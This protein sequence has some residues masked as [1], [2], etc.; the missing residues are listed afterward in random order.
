MNLISYIEK[1]GNKTFL[2]KPLNGVDKLILSNLSYV[3]FTGIISK[4]SLR[5][6]RL[7]TAG[8][9]FFNNKYDKGKKMLAVKGGIKLLKAM[10]KTDRY[11]NL[12]LFNYE[13]IGNYITEHT[14]KN[15]LYV[16]SEEFRDEFTRKK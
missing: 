12:L 5:K 16:T 3:E 8:E 13:S 2:D 14:N 1:Y 4:G 15:V 9:E 10:Y 6:K 7:E 11:K